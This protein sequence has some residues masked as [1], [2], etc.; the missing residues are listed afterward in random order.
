[1]S[2]NLRI[3][4]D[5]KNNA[6]TPLRQLRGDLDDVSNSKGIGAI[7]AGFGMG[8]GMAVF[9]AGVSAIHAGVGAIEDMVK[10]AMADEVATAKL[11]QAFQNWG[12]T[13]QANQP[14]VDASIKKGVSL[15]FTDDEITD[16]LARL[17]TAT[18]D[19]KKAQEFQAA[20]MDL[21]RTK[22]ISLADATEAMT[23][24][25][26]GQYRALK[27]LGISVLPVTD[28]MDALT[29]SNKKATPEQVDQ[30]KATDLAATKLAVLA[31]VERVAGGQADA[32]SKTTAGAFAVVSAEID[33]ISD[34]IGTA[35]LPT[36]TAAATFIAEQAIPDIA[37]AFEWLQANVMPKLKE[38]F[39]SF[40]VNVVPA[41]RDAFKWISD[42]VIPALGKAFDWITKNVVPPLQA[43][44]QTLSTQVLPALRDALDWI[45]KN[46]MP[47]LVTAFNNFTE[48]FVKPLGN[49]INWVVVNVLPPL[50]DALNFLGTTV[51]PAIGASFSALSDVVTE[52]MKIVTAIIQPFIDLIGTLQSALDNL[53]GKKTGTQGGGLGGKVL[54]GTQNPR[55]YASGGVVPG[56]GPQLAIVHGG[57]TITPAG[58]SGGTTVNI[59]IDRGAF[60]DG[61]SIDL[62]TRTIASRLR[63]AGIS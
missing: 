36:L 16:S 33:K 51:L 2:N 18:G 38:A 10:G 52:T 42:N 47:K 45:W 28:A 35:L 62:L 53:T 40:S 17:V 8:I 12:S 39:D 55:A 14:A 59:H 5:L 44:F 54:G 24:V 48:N 25:E 37:A 7:T 26:A 60:I 61:P 11:A 23:K 30:A 57:E 6:S 41:L 27:A 32:Y 29:A 31:A 63:L 4:A 1:M 22:G 9:N 13:L 56:S 58:Q 20:A 46:V 3:T 19:A 15:G 43:I 50:S 49:V 21:A 34:D